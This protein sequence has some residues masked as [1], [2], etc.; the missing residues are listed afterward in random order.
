VISNL[1]SLLLACVMVLACAEAA[2]AAGLTPDGQSKCYQFGPQ[3]GA[4]RCG[5]L[6][7]FLDTNNTALFAAGQPTPVSPL[8]PFPVIIIGGGGSGGGGSTPATYTQN[9]VARPAATS[10]TLIGANAVRRALVLLPANGTC[11]IN[12]SGNAASATAMP[13]P[14]GWSYDAS[15]PPPATAV[16]GY[17][18]TA[19][20]ISVTEGQ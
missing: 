4:L 5:D 1:K 3:S 20:T 2:G 18:T 19:T 7:F 6:S 14:S 12:P 9:N 11:F 8:T 15:T 10:T 13:I 17:C 16:T